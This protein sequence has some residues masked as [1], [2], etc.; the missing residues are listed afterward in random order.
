VPVLQERLETGEPR[1]EEDLR[2]AIN[3]LLR[4]PYMDKARLARLASGHVEQ[5]G[6]VDT[7]AVLNWLSAWLV[8][9]GKPAWSWVEQWLEE[10]P[11]DKARERLVQL[12]ITLTPYQW[13]WDSAARPSFYEPATVRGMI[14]ARYR[15]LGEREE[16]PWESGELLDALRFRNHLCQSLSESKG[17]EAQRELLALAQEP[18]LGR[19]RDYFL[20]L[21]DLQAQEDTQLEPWTPQRLAAFARGEKLA[22][23]TPRVFISY[24][25]EDSGEVAGR[26]YG[27]LERELGA[28]FVFFDVYSI[29]AAADFMKE[30]EAAIP[31][32]ALVIA[33]IGQRWVSPQISDSVQRE[34]EIAFKHDIPVVPVLVQEARMPQRSSQRSSN[35]SV[36]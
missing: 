34:L 32:G 1:R 24:R 6:R 21:A 26:I 22:G 27:A 12:A 10:A 25:R 7:P 23:A 20:Y 15:Y 3:V 8:S 35:S 28:D 11:E 17:A 30:I 5:R 4:S 18:L 31:K 29:P 9:D 14:L 2:G 19:F 13:L 36:A 16:Q 33:I